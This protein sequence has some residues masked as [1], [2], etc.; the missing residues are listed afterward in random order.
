MKRIALGTVAVLLLAACNV[1]DD[2]ATAANGA[3]GEAVKA[4][5]G[6]DLTPEQAGIFDKLFANGQPMRLNVEQQHPNGGVLKLNSIQV[7]PTETVVNMTYVNGHIRDVQLN[8]A[9]GS[10]R[11]YLL[12]DGRKFNVSPPVTDDNIRVMA[13]ATIT[14]DLVFLGAVPETQG[15]QLVIN[16]NGGTGEQSFN[17]RFVVDIPA[18]GTA[19]NDDGS[20]KKSAA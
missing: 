2:G 19:W 9:T 16:E 1:R 12:A 10:K 17:P 3:S 15:L 18:N 8:W 14:G 5:D 11:T 7:K 6:T 13:G 20:K 4:A